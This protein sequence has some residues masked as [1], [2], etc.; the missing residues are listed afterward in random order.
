MKRLSGGVGTLFALLALGVLIV[1][2]MFFFRSQ[3]GQFG[4]G[5]IQSPVATVTPKPHLPTADS[6]QMR[7]KASPPS[8]ID[9]PSVTPLPISKTTDLA[10]ELRQEDKAQVYVK[11]SNGTFEIFWVRPTAEFSKTIPLQRGDIIFDIVSPASM[12]G[13]QPPMFNSPL[14]T[15]APK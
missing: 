13:H 8:P 15:P 10:P 9:A 7:G 11:R 4:T 2:L 5:A 12:M 3:Q 6:S 1:V 14:P